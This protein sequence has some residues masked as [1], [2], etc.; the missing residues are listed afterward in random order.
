MPFKIG[1]TV[2]CIDDRKW[3]GSGFDDTAKHHILIAGDQYSVVNVYGGTP[4]RVDV[5]DGRHTCVKLLA[6]RF[7]LVPAC[8]TVNELAEFL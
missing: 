8:M 2:V 1:D 7:K 4:D 6:Q 5:T 3:V